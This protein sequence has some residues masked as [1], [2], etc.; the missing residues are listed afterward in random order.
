MIFIH[1]W[2]RS[3][4]SACKT[5]ITFANMALQQVSNP[6]GVYYPAQWQCVRLY[7][8]I[9]RRCG[10][11]YFVDAPMNLIYLGTQYCSLECL[12]LAISTEYQKPEVR[13]QEVVLSVGIWNPGDTLTFL[14]VEDE[15]NGNI[16]NSQQAQD[17]H[18]PMQGVH[19]TKYHLTGLSVG[20]HRFELVQTRFVFSTRGLSAAFAMIPSVAEVDVLTGKLA[21]TIMGSSRREAV[22]TRKDDALF[23]SLALERET[24][25]L[26]LIAGDA[27]G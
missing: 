10:Y 20:S 14:S 3:E 18:S 25:P 21:A 24:F 8:E 4:S 13:H 23:T 27:M 15:Y 9:A 16:L 5:A 2:S 22:S 6:G 17:K 26:S 11:V 19:L 7:L 1:S 12:S